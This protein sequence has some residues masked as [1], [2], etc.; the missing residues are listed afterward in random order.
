MRLKE[1]MET[2]GNSNVYRKARR[3]YLSLEHKLCSICPPHKGCNGRRRSKR[4]N[5]KPRYK[6][7]D[8]DTIC[9]DKAWLI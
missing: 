9:G 2:T 3:L 8:R 5:Q 1:E 4:G 7:I 6:N